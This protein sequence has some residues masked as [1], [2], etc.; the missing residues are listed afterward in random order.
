MNGAHGQ[1][2]WASLTG[3]VQIIYVLAWRD[4]VKVAGSPRLLMLH[5]FMSVKGETSL[6]LWSLKSP[7]LSAG[8]A[9]LQK[10]MQKETRKVRQNGFTVQY[11]Q[12]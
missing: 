4:D 11:S 6:A 1:S 9:E 5:T 7:V 10:E 8:F 2:G 3:A 12:Y